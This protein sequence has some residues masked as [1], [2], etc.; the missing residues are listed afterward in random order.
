MAFDREERLSYIAA[1]EESVTRKIQELTVMQAD[2]TIKYQHM[3]GV[4]D[5]I[6]RTK[7]QIAAVHEQLK[8]K[9]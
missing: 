3:Q 1:L 5:S 2:K 7:R 6:Y 8:L 4:K 9:R